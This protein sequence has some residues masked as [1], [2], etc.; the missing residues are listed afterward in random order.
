MGK[1]RARTLGDEEQEKKEQEAAEARRLAK[2]E[3]EKAAGQAKKAEKS[4]EVKAMD[5]DATAGQEHKKGD[6]E[7]VNG[8]ENLSEG[9]TEME[10]PADA[11]RNEVERASAGGNDRQDPEATQDEVQNKP[12]KKKKQKVG[13]AKERSAKYKTAS[14]MVEESK[15]YSLSEALDLVEKT[16]MAKFDETV[17]LHINTT[18][19]LNG[20]VTLPHGTGK[21]T[22][23]AILNPNKDTAGA[24]ALLKEIESGKI[25][26]DILVATPDAM[27]KLAKVARILGPKGLMPNPKNGTVTPNPEAAAEKYAG[28]HMTFKTESKAPVLHLS[29]GKLS[30]GKTKLEENIKAAFKAIDM[31]NMKR[32]TLK[33]T[34]SPGIKLQ[35]GK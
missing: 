13:K 31:K 28:G 4:S 23:V 24:D 21:S 1:V 20:S 3:A 30:F 27:P 12:A 10:G 22:R 35:L 19:S 17:E 16:H 15:Q 7:N 25:N 9:V 14:A 11:Q 34:M 29:V 18:Q 2:I 6:E 26:F 32:V 33:S 5:D 8:K